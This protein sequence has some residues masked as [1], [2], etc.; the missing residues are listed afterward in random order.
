ME[1]LQPL[2]ALLQTEVVAAATE[3][4]QDLTEVVVVAVERLLT[5]SP[6]E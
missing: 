3:E 1:V 5:T 6:V 2:V 4:V